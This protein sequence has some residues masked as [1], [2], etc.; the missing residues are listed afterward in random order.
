MTNS[1]RDFVIGGGEEED[2]G[3]S[4]SAGGDLSQEEVKRAKRQIQQQQDRQ[5]AEDEGPHYLTAPTSTPA[6]DTEAPAIGTSGE[7]DEGT[8]DKAGGQLYTD[9]DLLDAG[10]AD[11]EEARKQISFTFGPTDPLGDPNLRNRESAKDEGLSSS[12]KL[13]QVHYQREAIRQALANA[14]I[15]KA[16][17][18]ENEI[19][20]DNRQRES[21]KARREAVRAKLTSKEQIVTITDPFTGLPLSQYNVG[22]QG[23][24]PTEEEISQYIYNQD[25]L[26]LSNRDDP[27]YVQHSTT[28]PPTP[29]EIRDYFARRTEELRRS[30]G[31]SLSWSELLSDPAA[32]IDDLYYMS[33]QTIYA[34][35]SGVGA[36]FDA[37]RNFVT[38]APL[39]SYN[40]ETGEYDITPTGVGTVLG[41][42]AVTLVG[43]GLAPGIVGSIGAGL[44][45]ALTSLASGSGSVV[46]QIGKAVFTWNLANKLSSS[47]DN[48]SDQVSKGGSDTGIDTGVSSDETS[49]EGADSQAPQ[50]DG[51]QRYT[52]LP[53]FGSHDQEEDGGGNSFGGRGD[54][55]WGTGADGSGSDGN[56]VGSGTGQPSDSGTAASVVETLRKALVAA[57]SRGSVGGQVSPYDCFNYPVH[58]QED[59]Q[60]VVNCLEE[61]IKNEE[62][63]PDRRITEFLN[64][65]GRNASQRT[66][67][68][69]RTR[70]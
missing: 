33:W 35:S 7:T 12:E 66:P 42:S 15:G 53:N 63:Q 13:A 60:R 31:D 26:A 38:K 20:D 1:Y 21:N 59:I 24:E 57:T 36:G 56:G 22:G 50:D 61:L 32:S 29:S 25:Q 65:Y 46:S 58:S 41:L 14:Y 16:N 39:L 40:T 19:L 30:G 18:G 54:S 2:N 62:V 17:E 45:G 4:S 3:T 55:T 69:G 49:D 8:N 6:A 37:A 51:N 70:K 68:E 64:R 27:K 47:I 9:Q 5:E 44:A 23:R 10:F 67:K 11:P 28:R 48:L 43:L 52:D 34:T